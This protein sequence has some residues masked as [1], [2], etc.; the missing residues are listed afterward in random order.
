LTVQCAPHNLQSTCAR[1]CTHT[2]CKVQTVVVVV[3]LA[4]M[5]PAC[6]QPPAA[7]LAHRACART[8]THGQQLL[9]T[10]GFRPQAMHSSAHPC[11]AARG[12][13]AA[14]RGVGWVLR[15]RAR[16]CVCAGRAVGAGGGDRSGN[17]PRARGRQRSHGC[18]ASRRDGGTGSGAV[19]R[20]SCRVRNRRGCGQAVWDT[21]RMCHPR[22]SHT[23]EAIRVGAVKSNAHM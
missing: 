3:V 10:R 23:H 6:R 17:A 16:V 14:G 11:Y 8:H 13:C 21:E 4:L 12:M 1:A 18:A 20:R 7:G 5:P 15:A 2:A 19:V 9:C 22:G